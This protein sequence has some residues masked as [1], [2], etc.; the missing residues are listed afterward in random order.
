MCNFFH[1]S[2][3]VSLY[4]KIKNIAESPLAYGE[5]LHHM[6]ETSWFVQ[7]RLDILEVILKN[8]MCL[9]ETKDL[10]VN[11]IFKKKVVDIEELLNIQNKKIL[12]DVL[13]NCKMT[14]K[15][16]IE[17][18]N[19]EHNFKKSKKVNEAIINKLSHRKTN[20]VLNKISEQQLNSLNLA[21]SNFVNNGQGLAI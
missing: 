13:N 15:T 20:V 3:K 5:L 14:K 12:I 1:I 8:P 7:D 19:S 16:L 9:E 11:D 2:P 6:V 17:F 21:L 10:I 4:Q 18:S